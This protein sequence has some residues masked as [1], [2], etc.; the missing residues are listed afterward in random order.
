MKMDNDLVI[1]KIKKVLDNPE[2]SPAEKTLLLRLFFQYGT[3]EF[4]TSIAYLASSFVMNENTT[5][6]NLTRLKK[7]GFLVSSPVYLDNGGGRC[8]TAFQIKNL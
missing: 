7:R 2:L 6:S 4:K 5:I 1:K 8:G 3:E